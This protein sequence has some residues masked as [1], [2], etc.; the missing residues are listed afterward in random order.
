M[1][2]AVLTKPG[3]IEIQEVATPHITDD[4]VLIKVEG[5]GIC[6]SSIPLWEG[7]EWFQYPVQAGS[8][9]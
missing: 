9:G 7:R 6:T 4:Q 5:C 3:E 1:I 8:P 2:A